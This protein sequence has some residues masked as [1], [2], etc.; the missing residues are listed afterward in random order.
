MR[1]FGLIGHPLSHSFSGNYFNRKFEKEGIHDCSYELYPIPSITA[2]KLLLEK[3][4]NLC[5]LN[6]TIPYKEAVL[7]YL[8]DASRAVQEIGACN[9]INIK[10][11]ILTGYNTDVIGFEQ[12]LVPLLLPHHK[13]A[14]LLGTGG[15]AKAVAWVLQKLKIEFVYVSRNAKEGQLSYEQ[16]NTDVLEDFRVII[17]STP[18]G[19]QPNIN[20]MPSLA[21]TYL[22]DQY[23]CYDLIY[24]REKRLS[25]WKLKNKGL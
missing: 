14:L 3:E 2:L 22:T 4:V 15:A 21:Y 17:N 20:Q 9:C 13:K 7:P 18:L 11:G 10:D 6:V 16:L 8:D 5:G 1:Q 23:L 24:T 19:M 25:C 12:T